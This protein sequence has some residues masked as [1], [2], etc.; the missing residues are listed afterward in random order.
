MKCS[1]CGED[2]GEDELKKGL[3]VDCSYVLKRLKAIRHAPP[4]PPEVLKKIQEEFM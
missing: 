4:I 3:C 2:F 1:G